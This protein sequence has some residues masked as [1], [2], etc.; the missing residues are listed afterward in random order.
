MERELSKWDG[1]DKMPVSNSTNTL[2]ISKQQSVD[3][4]KKILKK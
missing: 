3:F 2:N 1:F 4:G